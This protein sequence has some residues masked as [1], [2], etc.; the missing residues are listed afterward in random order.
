VEGAPAD[1]LWTRSHTLFS[2]R[3]HPFHQPNE[4]LQLK[5]GHSNG[6]VC[7]KKLLNTPALIRTNCESF[8]EIGQVVFESIGH[9]HTNTHTRTLTPRTTRSWRF[10]KLVTPLPPCSPG[11][12]TRCTE[13]LE[14]RLG[15]RTIPSRN[16]EE[17]RQDRDDKYVRGHDFVL[18]DR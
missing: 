7:Y 5:W 8:S 17:V 14:Y 18:A 4:M 3:V 16:V 11:R 15:F 13:D 6:R 1:R 2:A 10:S 12:C 9:T